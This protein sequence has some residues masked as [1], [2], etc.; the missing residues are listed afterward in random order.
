MKKKFF[1][2]NPLKEKPSSP[3][4]TRELHIASISEGLNPVLRIRIRRI[5]MNWASWIRIRILLPSNKNSKKTLI[6]TVLWLLFDFLSL[7]N[8][9]NYLQKLISRITVLKKLIFVGFLKVYDENR[10][11]WIQI[12]I[13]SQRHGS[14]D[15]DPDPHQNVLDTQHCLNLCLLHFVL[16]SY[17]T[18]T[19]IRY[20]MMGT[21]PRV[22][23]REN[24]HSV[25][26]SV[27][28]KPPFF[29]KIMSVL[30]GFDFGIPLNCYAS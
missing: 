19:Y 15:P 10:R 12:R 13:F 21:V 4:H 16:V 9:V 5:C 27:F 1:R 2:Y 14:A 26:V 29:F 24:R 22:T 11:I 7:K 25:T 17:R 8:D 18:G 30:G 20:L 23:Q 28:E 3:I 6:P